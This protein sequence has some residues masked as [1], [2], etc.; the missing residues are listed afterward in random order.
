MTCLSYRQARVL[1]ALNYKSLSI[2]FQESFNFLDLSTKLTYLT[3][4]PSF[5]GEHRAATTL[6]QRTR[7]WEVFLSSA[8]VI[9]VAF[10]SASTLLRQVCLGQPTF[11]FPCGFQ[12]RACLVTFAAGFRRMWPILPH[13]RFWIS[14]SIGA[15]VVLSHSCLFETTFGHL[16]PR[17]FL[18][19]LLVNVW[20]LWVLVLVTRQV[21][22][23]YSRTDFMLVLKIRI[24]LWSERPVDLQIGRRVL[25]AC[26][27]LFIRHS[28]SSSVP[29]SLLTTLPRYM[30]LSTS[31]MSS[32]CSRT[33]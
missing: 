18:R 30:N 26:L 16:M 32:W 22:A 8:Y 21:S 27:A 14:V 12:S 28:M 3:Y 11:R 19:H 1:Q 29:P 7:F 24:F 5:L 31:L 33:L 9:P 4:A 20:S 17:M 13:F 25:K 23:P 2:R 6:L 10:T 15:C